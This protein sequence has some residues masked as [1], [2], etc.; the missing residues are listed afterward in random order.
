MITVTEMYKLAESW[1]EEFICK[2]AGIGMP[3]YD[4][5]LASINDHTCDE[6]DSIKCLRNIEIKHNIELVN[7]GFNGDTSLALLTCY[8]L[9]KG[10]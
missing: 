3:I 8:I 9:L 10:K 1:F 7:R 5:W 6:E 4:I 2:I